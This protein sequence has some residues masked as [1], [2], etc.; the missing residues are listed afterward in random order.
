[1]KLLY[2]Y[3]RPGSYTAA[4][5]KA[6]VCDGDVDLLLVRYPS[7]KNSPVQDHVFSGI[8]TVC[9]EPQASIDELRKI[10]DAFTPDTVIISGWIDKRYLQIAR[11]ARMKGI[12]TIA[13]SD[14]QWRGTLKQFLSR[15][16]API[17]LKPA[18]DV[19]WVAGSRQRILAQH[20]GY[21][22][23]KLWDGHLCCDWG[24]FAVR[25]E[26]VKEYS[27]RKSAFMFSGRLV[28]TKGISTLLSAYR[29]YREV[30]RHPWEL[31]IAGTGPLNEGLRGL[32]GVREF[33]FLQ[34]EDLA[35]KLR[36]VSAFVLASYFEPWGLVVQEAAAAGL[37]LILSD[38]VGASDHLLR[39][40]YNGYLVETG[41]SDMLVRAMLTMEE[42]SSGKLHEMGRASYQLSRQFLPEIWAERLLRGYQEAKLQ[43]G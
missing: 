26:S 15:S 22:G 38:E 8:N 7:S 6:L 13:G 31:W 25:N 11:E 4:C 33:G 20:L 18:I 9:I 5:L 36:E 40:G 23:S 3:T 27:N 41:S 16:A 17:K 14:T 24:R 42:N 30:S 43:S 21:T 28:E 19:L 10:L 29:K 37:P 35:Q 32:K 1:M 39:D 34:V 12:L 2:L